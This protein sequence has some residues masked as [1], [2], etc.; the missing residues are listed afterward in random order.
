MARRDVDLVIKARDEAAKV[1]DQITKAINGFTSA[2]QDMQKGADKS[3]SA[4]AGLGAAFNQLEKAL[5][6]S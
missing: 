4:L 1:V 2:S 3:E 5:S 6:D